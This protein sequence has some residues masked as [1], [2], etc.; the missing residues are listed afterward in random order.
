MAQK[1]YNHRT[2]NN[3]AYIDGNTVRQQAVPEHIIPERGSDRAKTERT[4]EEILRD[5]QRR[6]AA[7]RNCQRAMAMN[8]GYVAF[9]CAATLICCSVCATYIHIQ[10]DITTRMSKIAALETQISEMNEDNN[11]AEKRL[12]TTVTLEQVKE[13]AGALGLCYPAADQ[14]HY[15]SVES[16]DY[17]NQY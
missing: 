11:A 16:S 5:R 1:K 13:Q 14:I 12:E 3:S 8:G 7:K 2:T 9:L 10:S 15:Y 4:R 17:M 6:L